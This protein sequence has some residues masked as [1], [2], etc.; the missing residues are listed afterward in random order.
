MTMI[1]IVLLFFIAILLGV[2]VVFMGYASVKAAPAFELKKRLRKLALESD[3]RLP[4]DLQV[5]ILKEMTTIDR[6]LYKFSLIRRLDRLVESAGLKID[7][8]LVIISLM[9]AA[10]MG[11]T[12]GISLQRGVILAVLL[13]II[14]FIAPLIYLQVKKRRRIIKF[15]EEF[16]GAL[17]MLARSLRAGHSTASA[18]QMIGEELAD[19]VAGLFKTAY[20]EQTLGLSMRDALSR[21][22][23]RIPSVDLRL[24]LTAVNIHREVGGNLAETLERLAYTIRERIK[25]RRQIR[26]YTA[27]GRL[28]GIVLAALPIVMAIFLY[29]S[30]PDYLKELVDL[31]EGRYAIAIVVAGQII[32]MLIIRR[33]INIRI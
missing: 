3:E 2:A 1:T 18:I 9:I 19:P 10:L 21:M 5:E 8:K 20:E 6:F 22:Y 24:F 7:I 28:T 31:K 27:Q 32:G 30:S 17:D 12:L 25:I 11:F 14:A 16:P 33:L 15:T 23:E 29:V 4:S 26:V 13:A